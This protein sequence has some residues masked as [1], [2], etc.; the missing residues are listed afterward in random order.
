MNKNR[1]TQILEILLLPYSY[2]EREESRIFIDFF[3]AYAQ[4]LSEDNIGIAQAANRRKLMGQF[5]SAKKKL[6]D[7]L[8]EKCTCTPRNLDDVS[9]LFELFF[10]KDEILDMQCES[11][12]DK[13]YCFYIC[14][15]VKIAE[16]LLTFRDGMVSIRTWNREG[17]EKE[18]I[19]GLQQAYTL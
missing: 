6:I 4:M 12:E 10:P 7:Y 19:F 17:S 13:L 9:M 16:S 14:N 18:D 15:L 5:G 1:S 3:T 2:K 11:I 8:V